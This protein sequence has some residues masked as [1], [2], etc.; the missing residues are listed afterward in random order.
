MLSLLWYVKDSSEPRPGDAYAIPAK[1]ERGRFM[2]HAMPAHFA[3]SDFRVGRV[4]SRTISVLS[5]HFLIFCVVTL[6]ANAP[7]I[8]L[9]QNAVKSDPANPSLGLL[10]LG[11]G[12]SFVLS[13]LSQAVLVHASFQAMR[14][15]AVNLGESLRVGFTRFFPV[16]GVA[17]LVGILA[18]LG[19]M[20]LIVP[21][22]I[23]MTMWL[24]A[25]PVCV[26]EQ[27][28]PWTSMRRSSDLTR[29]HR[30]KVFGL[31]LLLMIIS[32]VVSQLIELVFARFLGTTVTLILTLIWTAIFGAYYAIAI[33]VTYHDLRVV[34]EGIDIEQ[35]AAVFD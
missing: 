11:I 30:W 1:N 8:L 31:W 7:V 32:G 3:E 34:K 27:S 12:L 20:L 18:G 28:G 19:F 35:I 29:G 9:V 14:N 21:G 22:L 23:L 33:V 4:L 26:V 2:T 16:L 24:I 5:Q 13:I 17:L 15:R 10:F 25:P 6:V